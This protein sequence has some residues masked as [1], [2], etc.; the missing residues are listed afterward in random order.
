VVYDAHVL[1]VLAVVVLKPGRVALVRRSWLLAGLFIIF[2]HPQQFRSRQN[3]CQCKFSLASPG[4][5]ALRAC[6]C[7]VTWSG[8]GVVSWDAIM[9]VAPAIANKV[10][11]AV[12]V[13]VVTVCAGG[14]RLVGGRCRRNRGCRSTLILQEVVTCYHSDAM[15]PARRRPSSSGRTTRLPARF[16]RAPFGPVV[17]DTRCCRCARFT[18][19]HCCRRLALALLCLLLVALLV[20]HSHLFSGINLEPWSAV[21]WW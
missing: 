3:R 18:C 13:L 8:R 16:L 6:V 7:F 10:G 2:H 1:A 11:A 21:R 19:C 5:F 15:P 17:K 4:G 12:L 14:A 20:V 9:A